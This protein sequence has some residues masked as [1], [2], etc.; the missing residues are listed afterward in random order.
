MSNSGIFVAKLKRIC[1]AITRC[2]R[3]I[4]QLFYLDS[5]TIFP[6]HCNSWK[7]WVNCYFGAT[8]CTSDQTSL[9]II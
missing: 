5:A 4:L 6:M 8:K 7:G 2:S 9:N 3:Q 1:D